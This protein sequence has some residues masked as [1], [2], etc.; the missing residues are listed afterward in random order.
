MATVKFLSAV[1]L[2]GIAVIA[3]GYKISADDSKVND[4]IGNSEE[5]RRLAE[6][7]KDILLVQ[8]LPPLAKGRQSLL[9]EAQNEKRQLE[10]SIDRK[11]ERDRGPFNATLFKLFGML[12]V[13]APVGFLLQSLGLK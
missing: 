9:N 6:V 8:K 2:S 10:I 3:C 4:A 1:F 5:Y 7:T 12:M 13:A 11:F